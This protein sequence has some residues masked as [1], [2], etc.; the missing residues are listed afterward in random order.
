M[1]TSDCAS[2]DRTGAERLGA[3]Y[4][5]SDFPVPPTDPPADPVRANKSRRAF[6]W[7]ITMKR[8]FLSIAV[9][10]A[11]SLVRADEPADAVK[12]AV[13][14]GLRLI[15]AGAAS[16]PKHRDCFSCHHQAT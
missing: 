10:L 2:W 9:V 16:Y 4:T 7:E 11:G 5:E 14:K 13:A 3:L 6:R 15:E 1:A 8:L 12:A